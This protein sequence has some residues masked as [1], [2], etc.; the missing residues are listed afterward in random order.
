MII[1]AVFILFLWFYAA[2][3]DFAVLLVLSSVIR[4]V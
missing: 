4:L 3:N 1:D 2:L